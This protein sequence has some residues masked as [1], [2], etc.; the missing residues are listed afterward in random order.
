MKEH[1]FIAIDCGKYATKALMEYTGKTYTLLFRTKMQEVTADIGV[2]IQPN[3]YKIGFQGK[4]YL[5]GDMVS[6]NNSNFDLSKESL[7][8]KLAIYA[9][10]VELMKK[11]N[12]YFHNIQLHLVINSPINVYKSRNLKDSF[13]KYIENNNQTV[14]IQINDKSHALNLND[15]TIAFEGTGLIYADANK[16]SNNYRTTT[17]IDIG[18]LNSTYCIFNG[19]QPNFDSM[20][21]SHLGISTL[22]ANLEN[23]LVQKYNLNVSANDLE[24]F[25]K[26]GY[27]SHMGKINEESKDIIGKIKNNHLEQILNYAKQHGYTFNQDIINF[28]GGGAVLLQKEIENFFPNAQIAINPQFANVKSFLEIIKVKY[29]S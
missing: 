15:I 11:A 18:G 6:E 23:E 16:Y 21:V 27:F 10:I 19:I 12:L 2:E 7:I 26:R 8:H 25:I 14:F 24:E 9:S 29:A 28:C 3:S 5:L 22:K 1:V 17:V 4:Q 20:I 13:K